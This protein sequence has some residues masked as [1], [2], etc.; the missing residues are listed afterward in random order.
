MLFLALPILG[1]P[2]VLPSTLRRRGTA[3]QIQE[4]NDNPSLWRFNKKIK[5]PSTE[6]VENV[7]MDIL[8]QNQSVDERKKH[9]ASSKDDLNDEET[10]NNFNSDDYESKKKMDLVS[11][12]N[13]EIKAV[14][15]NSNLSML[16]V[17]F[18]FKC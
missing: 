15:L 4:L 5:F 9:Y 3:T 13:K 18:V 14:S 16:T 11:S 7:A 8:K 2:K 6:S 17:C 10:A 12:E 1:Y